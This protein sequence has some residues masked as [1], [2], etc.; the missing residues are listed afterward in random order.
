LLIFETAPFFCK[1]PVYVNTQK[2]KFFLLP[3]MNLKHG[4]IRPANI[5]WEFSKTEYF[6]QYLDLRETRQALYV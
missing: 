6:G 3:C 4:L 2:H 1:H 5:D